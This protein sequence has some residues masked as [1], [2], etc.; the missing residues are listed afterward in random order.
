MGATTPSYPTM[1]VDLLAVKD[2]LNIPFSDSTQDAKLT[3]FISAITPV[4]E[5]ITGPILPQQ[6]EEWYDGGQYFIQLRHRPILDLIACSEFRGPIEYVLP[7]VADPAHG[8]IYSVQV[9]GSRVVRRSAGGGIVAFPGMPQAIH[10]VY[11]AGFDTVPANVYQG[12]LELIRIQFQHTQQGRPRP[13]ASAVDEG[14][15][16]REIMGFFV[17]Y[18]VR[19][20]LSPNRRHSS[21]A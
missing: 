2:Y 19:E 11:Q 8:Q 7:L 5:A 9:D 17:P 10:V 4:V 20:L 16:E 12:T 3:Q 1:L 21:V 14:M 13:G 15:P 18:S 6:Y